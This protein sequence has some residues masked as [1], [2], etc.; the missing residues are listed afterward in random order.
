MKKIFLV[1]KNNVEQ[2]VDV[3]RYFA[4]KDNKYLIYT[5]SEFDENN[6]QT[7]Y[8]VK[9]MQ[10]LGS[11]ILQTIR[12]DQEWANL[13]QDI[14]QIIKEIKKGMERSFQDID[15][16]EV[17]GLYVADARVFKLARP[18]VEILENNDDSETVEISTV[19]P[20]VQ[21]QVTPLEPVYEDTITPVE[22]VVDTVN[23]PVVSLDPEIPEEEFTTS[24]DITPLPN[25]EEMESMEEISEVD[26]SSADENQIFSVEPLPS[27]EEVNSINTEVVNNEAPADLTPE[28][29]PI[30]NVPEEQIS[31]PEVGPI[32]NVSETTTPQNSETTEVEGVYQTLKEQIEIQEQRF[33]SLTEE[34][35]EL[36]EEVN[37]F[38]K[39]NEEL[40]QTVNQLKSEIERYQVKWSEIKKLVD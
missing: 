34:N 18:I 30:I 20:V 14:R 26:D 32:F 21:E 2:E 9:E 1:M 23:E 24:P 8:V 13:K 25:L 12:D 38:Q 5:M 37:N 6:Y 10:E 17:N 39:I 35:K 19:E 22:E 27:I 3:V 29:E 11:P 16:E 33:I 7:L 4:Y 36:K 40:S 28:I 15:V 31:V